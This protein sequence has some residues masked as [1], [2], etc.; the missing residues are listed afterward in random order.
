LEF[1]VQL[2][3]RPYLVKGRISLSSTSLDT[4]VLHPAEVPSS[5]IGFHPVFWGN[6]FLDHIQVTFQMARYAP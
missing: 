2:G 5:F 3:H 1:A 4:V 6:L